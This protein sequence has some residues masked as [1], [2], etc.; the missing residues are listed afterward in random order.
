MTDRYLEESIEL[1][2]N[3]VRIPSLSFE[4]TGVRDLISVFL[5]ERG[6]A[7]TIERNNI[8]AV[9][10]GYDPINRPTLALDAHI[11]TVPA[12]KGYTSDPFEP[13]DDPT[14]VRGLGS[15]DDGGSVAAMIAV[16][17]KYRSADL[18]FNLMLCLTC[19]EERS[20]ADGAAWLY[21]ADGFFAGNSGFAMPDWVI[22]GEPTGLKAA[23]SERGLLVI[24]GHAQGVAGHAARGEGVNALYIAVEDI[25]RLKA[26]RFGRVSPVLGEV[27]MSVTQINA[28]S[29]HNVIPDACDFVVDIRPN[30]LYTN[31]ELTDELQGIC[32]STLHARRLDNRSSVTR[33]DSPLMRTV[34]ALGIGTFSS[35]TTSD[36]MKI[37]FCD[38]VKI[39]PGE[40]SRS[41]TADEYILTQEIADAVKVYS[42]IIDNLYGNTLE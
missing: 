5:S 11:D 24:D 37:P 4:E 23:T 22:V 16:F 20:G 34:S 39:G 17:R 18:P 33:Q 8:I 3:M 2:R 41:H 28:G 19:E 27:K 21:A 7:H 14:T 42:D 12:N 9:A 1:L 32:N 38:A 25:A 31:A 40:S 10:D 26:H 29:A 6:I 15:N 13:G 35:P 36:W 30:E